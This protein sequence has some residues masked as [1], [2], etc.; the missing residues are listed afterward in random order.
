MSNKDKATKKIEDEILEEEF[1]LA[2]DLLEWCESFVVAIFVVILV[3]IFL[4]R[5]IE[6]SGPSMNPTLWDK[7]RVILTHINYTPESGDIIVCNS[8]GLE[9]LIIKRCIGVGGDTVVVNYTN[10]TVAVNGKLLD[11]SY[12]N[13]PMREIDIL[14]RKYRNME[15][16][17]VEYV[18][19]VPENTVLVMGDNRNH[20]ADGRAAYV[21]FVKYEDILGKVVFRFFPFGKMGFLK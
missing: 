18:Y 7:E 4:L 20:S 12:I 6:V 17:D 1:S 3:F 21:G 14:D 16:S 8:T 9:K 10:N 11:E 19:H 15:S 5:V 13:E 2:D